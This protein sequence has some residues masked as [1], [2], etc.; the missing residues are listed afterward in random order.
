[1]K[2]LMVPAELKKNHTHTRLLPRLSILIHHIIILTFCILLLLYWF[3]ICLD[4]LGLFWLLHK[5]TN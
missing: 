1:M 5:T 3:L 2:Q 4:V